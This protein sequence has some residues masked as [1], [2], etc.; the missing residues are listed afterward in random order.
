MNS[1]TVILG[2]ALGSYLLRVSALSLLADREVPSWLDRA[3]AVVGPAAMGAIAAA[4]LLTDE[5]EPALAISPELI[6]AGLAFAV[7]RRTRRMTD[8]LVVGLPV[9]WILSGLG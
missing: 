2:A 1:W 5:G 3:L 6:A 4:M 8:S 7:V 9:L